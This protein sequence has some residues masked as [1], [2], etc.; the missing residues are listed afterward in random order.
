MNKPEFNPDTA[1]CENGCGRKVWRFN[2]TVRDRKT[3]IARIM[4]I[5]QPCFE[6]ITGAK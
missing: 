3:K 2:E 4:N 6:K 1:K 5:C